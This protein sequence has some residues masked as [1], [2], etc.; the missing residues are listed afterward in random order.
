MFLLGIME[1]NL[2]PPARAEA[3]FPLQK[4]S[5]CHRW[6]QSRAAARQR[7]PP[8]E[9]QQCN[10]TRL[11]MLLSEADSRFSAILVEQLACDLFLEG[12]GKVRLFRPQDRL[13]RP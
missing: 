1:A 7:T 11:K 10:G 3:G 13:P 4:F 8:S 5:G 9:Q 2:H 12:V 6:S